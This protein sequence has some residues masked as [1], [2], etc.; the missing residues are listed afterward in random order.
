MQPQ[1]NTHTLA[2]LPQDEAKSQED[3]DRE[4]RET[5]RNGHSKDHTQ[6]PLSGCGNFSYQAMTERNLKIEAPIYL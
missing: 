5:A 6:L 4:Y 2:H 3:D 1:P